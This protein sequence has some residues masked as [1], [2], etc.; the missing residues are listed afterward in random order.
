MK[1]SN[2]KTIIIALGTLL[3]G[4][5]L[6]WLF[7][8]GGVDADHTDHQ[9]A[10]EVSSEW[11][12]SMHPQIRQKEP[13]D[14]PICGM[15]L[16]PVNDGGGSEENPLE[17][18]MSPT[19]MQLASVQTAQVSKSRPV[20]KLRLTGKVQADESTITSQTTHISGRIEKLLLN[21][22]G[23]YVKKGQVIAYIYSPEL[24]TAQK[25]LFEAQKIANSNP[26]L[27]EAA[28][29]KLKNWKLTA[30]Q[31]ESI[32]KSGKPIESFPILADRRGIVLT[33]RVNL[34]D[35]VMQG[36]SLYEIA[37]LDRVWLL[38]DVYESDMPWVK[39]GDEVTY[40][41]QSLPGR[42][43][44]GKV[45]FID[46][47]ID[48]KTRVA[49]ARIVTAN[50]NGDLKPEMFATGII[51]SPVNDIKETIVVPKS[52]LMWTGKKSV[53]YIKTSDANGI[54]F[55][56]KEVM[57]GASLGDEIIVLEGLNEGDEIAIHGTFSIDAAAQLAGKPSMMNPDGGAVMTGHNH[58]NMTPDKINEGS[59]PNHSSHS[60]SITISKE[61]S[62]ALLPVYQAYLKAKESL[63]DDDFS[64]AI[65]ATKFMHQEL[66]KVNMSVFKGESHGHWM[67]FQ[68][69][70]NSDLQVIQQSTDIKVFR[71]QFLALSNDLITMTNT[72]GN[73]L[74]QALYIQH[75]PMANDNK[76]GDWMSLSDEIKNPYFG[77]AMLTCGEVKQTIQ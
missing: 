18:K 27:L 60:K 64:K 6:G 73:P 44:T 34:G 48:P 40:T 61:A 16:I 74:G 65:E 63:A 57:T 76:G 3:L 29:E 70:L 10:I 13:G 71:N 51:K 11:T 45:S 20:K 24:V 69:D 55:V 22:T 72:F 19:A 39:V 50:S 67:S 1:T 38:F 15:E 75:C 62:T 68:N 41:I 21:T 32:L 59:S 43:Y 47:V 56:M 17:I 58:G 31:I 42:E 54:G 77:A 33:K 5:G 2:Q 37:N 26:Q 46:P 14:C 28:K 49:K 23:E 53:A 35:H 66:N 30:R 7:F 9:H 52:A 4:L 12:C 8:T 36:A 25:E